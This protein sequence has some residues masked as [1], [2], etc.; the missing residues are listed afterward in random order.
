ME[1][2]EIP[3]SRAGQGSLSLR[4]RLGVGWQNSPEDQRPSSDVCMIGTSLLH[5]NKHYKVGLRACPTIPSCTFCKGHVQFSMRPEGR[6]EPTLLRNEMYITHSGVSTLNPG[7]E[8][9]SKKKRPSPKKMR[10]AFSA[11]LPTV[12][13]GYPAS[14]ED[15]LQATG[16]APAGDAPNQETTW[17]SE[18]GPK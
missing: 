1:D 6:T 5:C 14:R 7:R 13:G 3:R 18:R 9:V 2:K 15:Q 4:R 11:Q 8:R 10:E 16:N 17:I 12:T